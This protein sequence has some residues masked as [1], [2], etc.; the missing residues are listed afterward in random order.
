VNHN[1]ENPVTFDEA[2]K[3]LGV[4]RFYL[5]ALRSRLGIKS[6]VF[7]LSPIRDFIRDNPDFTTFGHYRKGDRGQMLKIMK[8]GNR[9][10][11]TM[12][13]HPEVMAEDKSLA[14]ALSVVGRQVEE[15]QST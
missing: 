5:T 3:Q 7:M 2:M 4:S 15:L 10:V 1:T 9:W 11:V 6:R 13:K 8:D 12:P 14:K